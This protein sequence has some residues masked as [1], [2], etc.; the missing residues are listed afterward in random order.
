MAQKNQVRVRVRSVR[1]VFGVI[2]TVRPAGPASHFQFG[3]LFA[4]RRRCQPLS[5]TTA[6]QLSSRTTD[7][8]L[9]STT[10]RILPTLCSTSQLHVG[11]AYLL[12]PY[13]SR[14]RRQRRLGA[15]HPGALALGYARRPSLCVS[16][17]LS[18]LPAERFMCHFPPHLK[19]DLA[20][21]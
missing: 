13:R 15:Q 10:N 6:Q 18:I 2:V 1:R 5:S 19:C 3:S 21:Q 8:P 16:F 7:P 17:P 9:L 11:D 4:V 20:I 12:I 14:T